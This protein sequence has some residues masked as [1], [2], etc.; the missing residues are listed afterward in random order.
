MTS[1][2]KALLITA[3]IKPALTV[4]VILSIVSFIYGYKSTEIFWV[5]LAILSG[6]FSIGLSNNYF[7]LK[8]DKKSGRTDKYILNGVLSKNFVIGLAVILLI[9]STIASLLISLPAGLVHVAALIIGW[10]YNIYFKN[11]FLSL[12]MYMLAF[13]L[14]PIFAA[15]LNDIDVQWLVVLAFINLGGAVHIADALS[16]YN[17][18]NNSGIKGFVNTQSIRS[19]KQLLVFF[20]V[21]FLALIAL[22]IYIYT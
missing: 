7:D 21:V 14:I 4:S 18:D 13:G 20:S 15:L 12:T 2:L 8:N 22:S 10:A 16:D 3:H 17:Y 19:N 1:K 5:F 9:I 6:Q 11:T